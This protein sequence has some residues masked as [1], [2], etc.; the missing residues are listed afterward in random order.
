[1]EAGCASETLLNSFRTARHNYPEPQI[2]V[3][4]HRTVNLNPKDSSDLGAGDTSSCNS[5]LKMFL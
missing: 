5:S 1:M 4:S 3:Q 2:S